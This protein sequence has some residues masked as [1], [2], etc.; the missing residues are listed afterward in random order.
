MRI[1]ALSVVVIIGASF[2]CAHCKPI[3]DPIT[4]SKSDTIDVNNATA[5]SIT[6]MINPLNYCST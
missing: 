5:F 4:P 3:S 2:H 1:N 6:V